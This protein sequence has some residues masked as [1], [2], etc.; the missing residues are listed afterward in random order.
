MSNLIRD[1]LEILK[2]HLAEPLFVTSSIENLFDASSR[3]ADV[4]RIGFECRLDAENSR[5]DLFQAFFQ[6]EGEDRILSAHLSSADNNA[7]KTDAWKRLKSFCIDW[8][9]SSSPVHQY[10]NEVWLEYD[11]DD[12][13]RSDVPSIFIGIN[14]S[15]Y[16]G[17]SNLELIEQTVGHLMGAP[18]SDGVSRNLRVCFQA[19]PGRAMLLHT[20]VM[21]SRSVDAL[22]VNIQRIHLDDIPSFLR[23]VQWTGDKE[24]CAELLSIGRLLCDSI[25]IDLDLGSIVYPQ[26]GLEFFIGDGPETKNRWKVFLERL[27]VEGL[28]DAQKAHALLDWSGY[29]SPTQTSQ[30]WPSSLLLDS[31]K[32]DPNQFG[33]LARTLN[34]VKINLCQNQKPELKAYL[35]FGHAWVS[36][37]SIVN[38]A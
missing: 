4:P 35:G 14:P 3:L 22:R 20:G 6:S 17:E 23:E 27:V 25:R 24:A 19:L 36:P 31:L 8:A 2:P 12:D 33:V 38:D 26:I 30:D 18:L 15:M 13:E 37:V 32:K 9:D 34:H 21:L 28:C 7:L 29:I 10:V 5:I 11:F 16:D 1:S